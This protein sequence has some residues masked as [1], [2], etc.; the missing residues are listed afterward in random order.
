VAATSILLGRDDEAR[1]RYAE[2]VELIDAE[3]R[4]HRRPGD[5]VDQMRDRAVAMVGL[6]P[7]DRDGAVRRLAATA[8]ANA[9]DAS[10]PPPV[11]S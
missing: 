2:L 9:R 5:W 4:T 11:L 1:R 10:I 6:L 8:A 3:D 7:A